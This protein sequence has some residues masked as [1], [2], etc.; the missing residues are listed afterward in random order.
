MIFRKAIQQYRDAIAAPFKPWK[1]SF[2]LRGRGGSRRDGADDGRR[3]CKVYEPI[4]P[5][6]NGA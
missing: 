2:L 1:I 4:G 6:G 3:I 5:S